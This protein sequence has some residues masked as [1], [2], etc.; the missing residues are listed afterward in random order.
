MTDSSYGLRKI[1][2]EGECR[3]VHMLKKRKFVMIMLF[4]ACVISPQLI[5]SF[6][7][8]NI[9]AYWFSLNVFNSIHYYES[10]L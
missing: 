2:L 8:K 4:Y 9:S 7:K 3:A 1:R 10:I 6:W 5:T